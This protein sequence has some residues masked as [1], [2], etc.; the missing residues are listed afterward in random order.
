MDIFVLALVLLGTYMLIVQQRRR[1]L[2]EERRI[3][4]MRFRDYIQQRR[5]KRLRFV[6]QLQCTDNGNKPNVVCR[7]VAA[8]LLNRHLASK[9]RSVWCKQRSQDWWKAVQSGLFG[10]GWWKENLRMSEQTFNSLC[11][12]L[13]PYIA[14]QV[15]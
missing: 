7:I 12:Q 8:L 2:E 5:R 6:L 14:K 4:R 15:M 10:P 3:R 11:N 1:R 13:R 9:R